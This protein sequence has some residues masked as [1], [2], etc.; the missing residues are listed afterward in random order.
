MIR[1]SPTIITTSSSSNHHN[2][3][4]QPSL[5][6]SYQ[7]PTYQTK[8][9]PHPTQTQ[10]LSHV[11]FFYHMFFSVRWFFFYHMLFSVSCIFLSDVFFLSHVFFLK[12]VFSLSYV[13]FL[14]FFSFF[15]RLYMAKKAPISGCCGLFLTV[16][17]A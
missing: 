2:H 12:H 8:R 14:F 1:I 5:T 16:I 15:H 13:L 7:Q 9:S 11:F 6:T 3:A 17:S 4:V 10:G